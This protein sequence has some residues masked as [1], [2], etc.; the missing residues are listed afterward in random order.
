MSSRQDS[1]D[2]R[3]RLKL[4]HPSNDFTDRVM[5]AIQEEGRRTQSGAPSRNVRSRGIGS[6]LLNALVA[7]AAT[8]LFIS[9]GVWSDLLSLQGGEFGLAVRDTVAGT[10]YT[11]IDWISAAIQAL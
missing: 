3:E 4:E 5:R 9:A 7:S 11:G 10:L 6:E 1:N 2:I 8:F